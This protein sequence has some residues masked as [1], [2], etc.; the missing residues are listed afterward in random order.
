MLL[1]FKDMFSVVHDSM[2]FIAASP[3]S[4]LRAAPCAPLFRWLRIAAIIALVVAVGAGHILRREQTVESEWK[5]ADGAEY[6][7]ARETFLHV[8]L[9]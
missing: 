5:A 7:V 3:D 1:L 6:A 9:L 8:S 4:S 2:V